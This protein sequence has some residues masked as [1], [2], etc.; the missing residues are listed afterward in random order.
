MLG[1]AV[2]APSYGL[3][4]T[5]TSDLHRNP[6]LRALAIAL[7]TIVLAAACGGSESTTGGSNTGESPEAATAAPQESETQPDLAEPQAAEE[8]VVVSEESDSDDAPESDGETAEATEPEAPSDPFTATLRPSVNQLHVLGAEPGTTLELVRDNAAVASGTADEFGSFL[9]RDIDAGDYTVTAVDAISDSVTVTSIGDLPPAEFYTDQIIDPGFGYV[10]TRDGTTLSL[11]VSLPGGDGPFPTVVEYSGYA[12]SNPADTTSPLLYNTLGFAYVGVNMRGTGCSGGSFQFFEPIQ[13]LDG[14]DMIEAIAAQPWVEHNKVG[15]VGISYPG[16]SQLFVAETQPPS[17]AAITPLSVIDDTFR[18]TLYPGGVLN[19]GFAVDWSNQRQ[20]SSAPYGQGWEQGQVD[21]GDTICEDN[22]LLRGQNP[23]ALELILD[24]EFYEPAIADELAPIGFVDQI[25]V[26][27]FMAGAWQDE[28][29]GGHFPAMINAFTSS[30]AVFATMVNGSHTESLS[31][32][33]LER[34]IAFLDLYVARRVPG[35]GA[36]LAAPLLSSNLTGQAVTLSL[37]PRFDGLDY[38][39][40]VAE[41]EAD[42]LVRVLFEEGASDGFAPGAPAPRYEAAFDQWPPD[43][44]A[45]TWYLQGDG[46]LASSPAGASD[47]T[48]YVSDPD[49]LPPTTY[50]GGTSGV[51][52]ASVDYDWQPIAPGTGADWLSTPLPADVVTVG[53]GSLDLWIQADA[54]DVDLEITLTEVRPNGDEVYV[55]SGWLRASH[56]ALDESLSTPIS[57]VHTHLATDA[58]PL[59]PGEFS[60]LRVEL[61]PFA[62]AF[63]AGSQLRI[64]VDAPGGA[65]PLWAFAET[66]AGGANVSIAHDDAHPSALV[67]NVVEGIDVPAEYPAC[68]ALRSQPCRTYVELDD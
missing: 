43:G 40:A 64:T 3:V 56:R 10:T 18:S 17:L 16:I 30:P 28:Q 21:A 57:P 5:R 65:R 22:Q 63:R 33:I 66:F 29:T 55:Q 46:S 41:F 48:S 52:Q 20:S 14:Y 15:M 1:I 60:A 31:P 6:V 45:T 42:A 53:P 49:A 62:H 58:A 26:P 67:L 68:E 32:A 24:N 23:D 9:W 61:F 38:E 36:A 47:P 4:V 44:T 54:A 7:A 25:N 37:D 51:W 27:V 2:N 39:A 19:T 12:P 11:N 13:R 50:S 59:P 34:Y 35:A 8:E